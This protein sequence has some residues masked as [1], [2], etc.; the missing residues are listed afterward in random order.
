MNKLVLKEKGKGD[1]IIIACR[2]ILDNTDFLFC[3]AR[4]KGQGILRN[5][6]ILHAWN[7]FQDVVFD[8]S[9][10]HKIVVR[11]EQYYKLADIEE[12][13]IIKMSSK[14]TIK[15]MFETK[16]YGGWIDDK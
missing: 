6:R 8:F 14:E 3:Y 1:C 16:T 4:V 9:N 5:K 7:E 15:K 10:G 11:K 2:N 12:K 13:D